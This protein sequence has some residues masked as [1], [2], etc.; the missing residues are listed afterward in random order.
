MR[1]SKQLCG[2][3]GMLLVKLLVQYRNIPIRVAG[4]SWGTVFLK[5]KTGC[6]SIDCA[7]APGVIINNVYNCFLVYEK[8]VIH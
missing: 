7:I 4:N 8:I 5:D 1:L 3:D 2:L 6:F